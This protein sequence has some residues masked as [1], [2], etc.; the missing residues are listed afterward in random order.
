MARG[1][2]LEFFTLGFYRFWL[3]TDIRQA[4]VVAYVGRR[5]QYR[6]HRHPQG[7][8]DRFSVRAGRAGPGLPRVFPDRHRIRAHAGVRQ[9]PAHCVLLHIRAVRRLS[10][11]PLS[12]DPHGLA[13]RAV[14]D[15][16]LGLGLCRAGGTLGPLG[17]CHARACAAMGPGRAR[18]LQDAPYLL[19]RFTRPL[20]GHRLGFFQARLVAVVHGDAHDCS[21]CRRGEWGISGL[22][23][24]GRDGCG[25][26]VACSIGHHRLALRLCC[27]QSDRMAVVGFRHPLW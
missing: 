11:A 18:T 19:R 9:H 3:T 4:P 14:L 15:D 26:G 1:A 23:R 16:R 2:L 17:G 10:C 7:I 27:V 24:H 12:A 25:R 5:R 21:V 6:V 22:E 8:A 13:R 20:R